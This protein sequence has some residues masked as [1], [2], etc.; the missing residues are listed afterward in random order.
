MPLILLAITPG[1]AA[2]EASAAGYPEALRLYRAGRLEEAL[3]LITRGLARHDTAAPLHALAGWIHLRQ[4]S[5]DEA[6]SEFGAALL[7]E[8]AA[9]DPLVGRGY[10][11][12]RRGM[13][14]KAAAEFEAVLR[15]DPRNVDALKGLGMAQRD[16]KK[17]ADAAAT[18]RQAIVIAPD[19]AEVRQLLDQAL[20]VSGVTR[21]S[22]P[23]P[24][25]PPDAPIR[26]VARCGTG[27]IEVASASGFRPIFI[28]G[29]NMGVALPGRFPA[30]FPV[31]EATY[32]GW[33]EAI[34]DLGA[35]VVRLYTLL[36]P[37]FY[38][39]LDR[40]NKKMGGTGRLWLMQGVWTELPDRHAYDDPAF[41]GGF[42]D[43]IRRVIDAVHGNLDL[44]PR[45][46]HASGTYRSDLSASLLGFILG[47]EWEPFSVQAFDEAQRGSQAPFRGLYFGTD[48]AAGAT[49]FEQWLARR[50]EFTVTYETDRY[51]QQ[52][53]VSFANWPTLDPLV[54]P[55]ESTVAEERALL[56]KRGDVVEADRILEYDNDGVSVD[57]TH[58]VPTDLARGG[59]FA[60]YHAYPYYPDFMN[61]DPG[62]LKARDAEGPSN[63]YGY[64]RDLKAHHGAQPVVIAEF[65]VPSS[66]GMAHVQAQGWNHGG[67]DERQQGEIDARLMRDIDQAGLAGGILFALLDEWFKKNWLVAEFETPA[68]R[69]PL[70]H[71]VLDPEQ[72]YGLL[73]ARAG[74]KGWTIAIDGRGDDWAAIRPL[75]AKPAGG[76]ARAFRDGHDAARTLRALSVTSDETYVYVRLDVDRLDADGDGRPD[77][78]EAIYVIGIDTY[79][80]RRGDHRL[81]TSDQARV[82]IG[83]EFCVILDGQTT[84]RLL[85]DP[86]YDI[87]THRYHR[88]YGSVDNDDGRFMEIEVETNRKRIGRDGTVFPARRSSRSPLL[89]GSI[90]RRDPDHTT[91]ADWH[92]SV[93]GNFIEARLGW[94]LLNVTD[95]SS[96]RVLQDDPNDLRR[97]GSAETA[98]L[99][100]YVA[101]LRPDGPPGGGTPLPGR[102][103]D[104][105]PAGEAARVA[106][107]PLYTWPGWEQPTWRIEKKEAW[108]IVKQA[109][110]KIPAREEVR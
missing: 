12:L 20:A 51:R 72:N 45:P 85:V 49:P 53:P 103:A 77:W 79:D 73:A 32:A 23:R 95:P 47:R 37:A 69:N 34:S 10:I 7:L 68:E 63:Y 100:F 59:S 78:N 28:K 25:L 29:V 76:P 44:P 48:P 101:A 5:L 56:R 31:D 42:Q 80:P 41:L 89:H 105:L 64:L 87:E 62:Y 33:L 83:A 97:I 9:L 21:E 82:P 90:D 39:A 84:S 81:P 102:L 106:E 13:P 30:D 50:L 52:R 86:P 107:F 3:A 98:G 36:P 15:R 17:P 108:S 19:D 96:H 35:N 67:H 43:E 70:W 91:L 54:H 2:T 38:A 24:P 4:G 75:L 6:D 109:L 66:R 57:A 18:F 93:A 16:G 99:R 92:S 14:A 65:G 110:K 40:H 61:L 1:S 27:R 26:V 71:N 94:G 74:A 88:P 55:T 60:T 22:R 46:G 104:R 11:L 8:P 58:I